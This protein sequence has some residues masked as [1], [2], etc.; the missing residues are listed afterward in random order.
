MEG[1][2]WV[3]IGK[4]EARLGEINKV[5]L[6]LRYENNCRS[7]LDLQESHLAIC[8]HWEASEGKVHIV[9]SVT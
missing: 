6:D 3:F 5:N 7:F 9:L 2:C 8:K 4:L 1:S